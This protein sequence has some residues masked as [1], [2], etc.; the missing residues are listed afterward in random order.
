VKLFNSCSNFKLEELLEL[1]LHTAH[2]LKNFLAPVHTML[3]VAAYLI[4]ERIVKIH[5]SDRT[6]DQT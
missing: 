6:D 5:A 4:L 3:D 1:Y 2:A